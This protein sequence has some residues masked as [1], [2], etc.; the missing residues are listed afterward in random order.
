MLEG[1]SPSV[2]DSFESEVS[3]SD[4]VARW[5]ESI[6]ILF[7]PLP[8]TPGV[9]QSFV[10]CCLVFFLVSVSGVFSLLLRGFVPLS[11]GECHSLHLFSVFLSFGCTGLLRC[12]RLACPLP[13]S[14]ISPWGLLRV[15]SLIWGFYLCCFSIPHPCASPT[16]GPFVF[17]SSGLGC[18]PF[19]CALLLPCASAPY[20]LFGIGH[21]LRFL[22]PSSSLL[23]PLLLFFGPLCISFPSI[24]FSGVFLCPLSSSS[25]LVFCEFFSPSSCLRSVP[26]LLLILRVCARG[27]CPP[28]GVLS[29]GFVCPALYSACYPVPSSLGAVGS[30]FW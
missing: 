16:L 3:L 14:W 8:F 27:R 1:P 29:L 28:F 23:I 21:F 24:G 6:L 10:G 2:Y 30:G 26:R 19:T 13:F 12:F 5:A 22:V 20:C 15:P 17:C 18:G 7:T 9:G 4:K 25:F 11:V